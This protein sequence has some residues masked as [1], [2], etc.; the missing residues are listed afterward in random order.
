MPFDQ[1]STSSIFAFKNALVPLLT[2]SGVIFS[3]LLIGSIFS[4]VIFN[5]PGLGEF[6]YK[7]INFYDMP[8]IQGFVTLTTLI[9]IFFNLLVDLFYSYVDP[10]IRI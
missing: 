5:F 2:I 4:D 8:L 9:F 6:L 3:T 10:K 1:N 7:G